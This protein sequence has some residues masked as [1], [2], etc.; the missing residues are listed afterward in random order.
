MNRQPHLPLLIG[1]QHPGGA[2]SR[3]PR[4]GKDGINTVGT[5]TNGQNIGKK[6]NVG[7]A[8]FKKTRQKF[9]STRTKRSDR[10]PDF[11][12]C[13][14]HPVRRNSLNATGSVH[15]TPNLTRAQHT[16][17]RAR[18][19]SLMR[20][21]HGSSVSG[22]KSPRHSRTISISSFDVDVEPPVRPLIS[23]RASSRFQSSSA[24]A[25]WTWP[26]D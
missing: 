3:G 13:F 4:T 9:L 20:T 16:F 21:P 10:L 17:S 25:C 12:N 1:L 14:S 8:D 22:V 5:V 15:R 18:V 2:R 11:L 19:T 26:N 23:T 7:G 24:P 6:K